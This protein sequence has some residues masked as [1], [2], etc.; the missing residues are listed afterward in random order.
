VQRRLARGAV[1]HDLFLRYPIK[2][3]NSPEHAMAVA[4][5]T[6]EPTKPRRSEAPA[7]WTRENELH[8]YT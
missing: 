2:D 6:A 3:K 7:A 1:A 5:K 8:A 4:A